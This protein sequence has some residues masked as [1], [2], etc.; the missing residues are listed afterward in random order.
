VHKINRSD[1][2]N[3]SD[4]ISTGVG[5]L[6]EILRGGLP[7]ARLYLVEGEPGTGKT[8]L[9]LQFLLEGVRRGESV[10]YVSLSQTRAELEQIATSH[11]WSLA[12]VNIQELQTA[13]TLDGAGN[14]SIFHS[15]DIR[16]DRTREM[17]E[18]AIAE[19]AP[20]RIVYDSLLEIRQIASDHMRYRRELLGFKSLLNNSQITAVIMDSPVEYG[21]DKQLE[22]LA[23]GIIHLEKELPE[24]G[25]ARRR[26]EVRKMRGVGFAD[27][28][29]DMSIRR[30]MGVSVYPRII[31]DLASEAEHTDL[32]KSGLAPLDEMLGGGMEA[33]TTT[34]V[35]G[36]A[37]TGKS[38]LA[39]LYAL[40]ALER[41]EAVAM[42]LFEERME[43]LFRR[44][45]GLG[46]NL[47]P[48]Y[49]SKQ[50]TINDFNPA[51][52]S[53]GEF[54]LIVRDGVDNR[55]TRVVLI[56][57]F[58][59]YLSALPKSDQ[60]VTQIQSLLKYLA[61]RGVLTI[62]IVAQHGLLGQN[63]GIDVD[64]SFV[65]DTVLLLRLHEAP[66]V[67][68]RSIS[69]VKKRHGPH[70][71]DVREMTINE[72]GIGIEPFNPAPVGTAG[73]VVHAQS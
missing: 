63:V 62:L 23:H 8:T 55:N 69:I 56:D 60:A 43:T 14:Q 3:R 67:L 10:L 21:G 46:L 1:A 65:G 7:P 16:L 52:I 15:A 38:T 25:I 39:S 31:P 22:G 30:G 11:G 17:V 40:A 57:S 6:D 35:T 49:E 48:Y 54:S 24:Y 59:G 36:Q 4:V 41:G 28:Y 47:R 9:G 29:H 45:E 18:K 44:S 51:E 2:M 73:L 42:Y 19:H 5:G 72:K 68:R 61:R 50:L 71:L 33:G 32:I 13:D 20:R 64:V 12:G 34:L 66:G 53:A 27:G 26:M 37:G 70:G 58:T